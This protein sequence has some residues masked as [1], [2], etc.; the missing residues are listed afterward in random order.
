MGMINE[1]CASVMCEGELC[2][3]ISCTGKLYLW[4]GSLSVLSIAMTGVEQVCC[5]CF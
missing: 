1:P 3:A 5:F 2:A 4:G